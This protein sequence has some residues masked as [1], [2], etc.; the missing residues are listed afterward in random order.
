MQKLIAGLH[1]FQSEIFLTRKELF[2]H[3][4]KGQSPEALFI[5]CSDSRISPNLMMQSH[6]G[7]LFVLRNAGNIVPVYSPATMGGG[8]AATIEFALEGL[9]IKDIVVCGHSHCGAI[10]GLLSPAA[11]TEMPSVAA[12]LVNAESTKKLMEENYKDLNPDQTLNAAI[13][14]NV[15]LQI[16]NL[17]THPAVA[18]RLKEGTLNL[19]GWVYKFETGEVFMYRHD[20]GQFVSLSNESVPTERVAEA[21]SN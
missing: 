9:K 14:E 3:L 6:P 2:E 1:Q 4:S 17:R 16:E 13:Q 10:K 8:E 11:L 21:T 15:L 12:W 19:H 18:K 7:D 20:E 5:T